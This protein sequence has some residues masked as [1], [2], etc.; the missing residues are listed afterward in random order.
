MTL[1]I[2]TAS[3]K[4]CGIFNSLDKQQGQ[5]VAATLFV[6]DTT[7]AITL[8]AFGILAYFDFVGMPTPACY[9]LIG[10]SSSFLV[11]DFLTVLIA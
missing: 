4:T 1:A 11:T 8:L 5:I 9:A 10:V 2:L 6:F 3:H 7:L